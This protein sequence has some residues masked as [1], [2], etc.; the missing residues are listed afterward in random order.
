M[1]GISAF[2]FLCAIEM[3]GRIPEQENQSETLYRYV[4][5][6]LSYI[7]LSFKSRQ[8]YKLFWICIPFCVKKFYFSFSAGKNTPLTGQTTTS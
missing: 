1:A 8:I 3:F 6:L 4:F 2:A 5:I 7:Y